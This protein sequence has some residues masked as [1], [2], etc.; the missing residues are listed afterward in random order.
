MTQAPFS[1][2]QSQP[3]APSVPS[4]PMGESE[5]SRQ[6][7]ETF[8]SIVLPVYNEADVL[9]KLVAMLSTTLG[10]TPCDFELVFV[11]DGSHDNSPQI[12]DALATR[13]DFVR[14]VH[15]ARN[16]GHQAA[17]HAGLRHARGDAVILMDSD[18]QDD[19]ACLPRFLEAWS[20]GADVVYAVRVK[21]KENAVKRLLF[22]SFYR[23]LNCLAS[24]PLPTDAG[25]FSLLDRQ[26]VDEICR[27][28]EADRYFPGLRNWVG[29]RQAGV[30]VERLRRHDDEPRVSTWQL[31]R[32]AKAAIFGFSAVPLS[33]FY[34]IGAA[35]MMVCVGAC[36]F[37]LYHRL[38][39]HLAIPGWTSITISSSFFGALNALG[40]AILG[41]YVV[42]IYDQV[43]QRPPYVVARRAGWSEGAARGSKAGD[44]GFEQS[45]G[46]TTEEF[47]LTAARESVQ[48]LLE[49]VE[50]ILPP[51]E[52]LANLPSGRN[53][54]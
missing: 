36:G 15:F 6:L 47:E 42:R 9:E 22:Y 19:P 26:V 27:M 24:S 17:V 14:V 3:L 31:F 40:I 48:E 7:E 51:T 39:T 8:V 45:D 44:A 2:Q 32:L 46:A 11:N 23:V 29:F 33:V 16:F 41:E 1:P 5:P 35:S 13:H 43:R 50:N 4:A 30:T 20:G 21:R 34:L 25:N 52:S 37:T 53:T 18:M 28:P 12:L 38:V 49:T 10:K 54:I